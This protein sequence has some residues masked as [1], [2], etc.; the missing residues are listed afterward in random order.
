[1]DP[2]L[3]A[4]VGI[5]PALTDSWGPAL[6]AACARFGI[7]TQLQQAAFLAQ[8]SHESDGL[9]CLVEN[10]NYSAAGLLTTW[11]EHFNTANAGAYAH[12]AIAIAS[13]AYANR[14]GNGDEASGDGWA[15]RGHGPIQSTGRSDYED[16]SAE[17]RINF[18]SNPDW[19]LQPVYGAL[20]AAWE[21]WRDNLNALATGDLEDFEKMTRAINGALLGEPDRWAKFQAALAAGVTPG[22]TLPLAA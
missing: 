4:A 14:D 21:W 8:I 19:L 3:L 5:K 16:L 11:P 2:G 10:L 9:T 17:T 6:D 12:N 20:A 18:V 15:F 7:L 1:M 22:G 13:H